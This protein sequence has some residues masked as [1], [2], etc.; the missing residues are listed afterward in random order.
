MNQVIIGKGH[1]CFTKGLLDAPE[2]Q[3][4]VE[5][6]VIGNC[7]WHLSK[8]KSFFF[9]K[10]HLPKEASDP[11]TLYISEKGAAYV[12]VTTEFFEP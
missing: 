2:G 7:F 1:F 5:F 3:V 9:S 12:D 11:L 4:E 8:E 6:L 10:R